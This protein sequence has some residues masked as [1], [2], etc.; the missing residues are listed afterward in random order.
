MKTLPMIA[1][2]AAGATLLATTGAQALPV[3]S[4][5]TDTL[6]FITRVE[7]ITSWQPSGYQ[8]LI[9]ELQGERRYL[10]TFDQACPTLRSA[11]HVNISRSQGKVYAG[12]DFVTADNS[13]CGIKTIQAL[14]S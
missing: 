3:A 4:K 14:K 12:F 7:H 11:K 9:V 13:R 8:Q 1:K 10:L 6:P 2:L 5:A